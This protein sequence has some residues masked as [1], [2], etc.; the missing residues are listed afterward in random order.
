MNHTLNYNSSKIAIA[1]DKIGQKIIP[2]K[3][4]IIRIDHLC[5]DGKSAQVTLVGK[6]QFKISR[7]KKQKHGYLIQS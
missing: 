4:T 5:K 7:L 3:N 1:A 2:R 6:P